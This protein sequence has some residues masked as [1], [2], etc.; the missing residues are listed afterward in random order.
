MP[1]R[2]LYG[3]GV[4]AWEITS[5]LHREVNFSLSFIYLA[6]FVLFVSCAHDNCQTDSP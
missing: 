1:V 3:E 5:S 6:S 4:P 2:G